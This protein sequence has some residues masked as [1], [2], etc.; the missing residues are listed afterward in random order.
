MIIICRINDWMSLKF[1]DSPIII[2]SN[3]LTN[4]LILVNLSH[5]YKFLFRPW[6]LL[7]DCSFYSFKIISGLSLWNT[8]IGNFIKNFFTHK[9]VSN[10]RICTA[11]FVKVSTKLNFDD[12]FRNCTTKV[13][14]RILTLRSITW[15][16]IIHVSKSYKCILM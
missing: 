5:S 6:L 8:S 3:I 2:L 11:L 7:V 1:T 12:Y 13:W 14:N 16:A 9:L 4:V 10:F 15:N